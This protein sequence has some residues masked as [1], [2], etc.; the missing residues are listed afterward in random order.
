[1]KQLVLVAAAILFVMVG[2]S[3]LKIYQWRGD[4]RDGVYAEKN[5]QE[6]WSETG[7][8]LL[9]KFNGIGNGY[10]SPVVT[11]DALYVCGEID[12]VTYLFAY[13]LNGGKLWQS[14]IG[15]EWT[16]NFRGSRSAPTIVNDLIYAT[17][18]N[19]DLVCFKLIDGTKLWSRNFISDFG[20]RN[21]RFG[22]SE[23]VLVDEDKVY[24]TPGSKDTNVVALNRFTGEL[25][26]VC[27]GEGEIPAY[28]APIM[29]EL[30]KRKIMVTFTKKYLLGIDSKTGEMLWS[31]KQDTMP[32]S[33]LDV[34][35]N[36]P[37]YENGFLYYVTGDGNGAVKL[38]L[39]DDGKTITEIW[40][41][42]LFDNV[43]GGFIKKDNYLY[44]ESYGKR[45]WLSL[46]TETGELV[47]SLR[48]NKGVTIFADGKLYLYNNKGEMALVQADKGKMEI[49][50][51]F[52][53]EK[54]TKEHFFFFFIKNGVLYLRHGELLMAYD[55]RKK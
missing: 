43:M 53:V 18:G 47:D 39:S 6:K 15:S 33:L 20:G 19:G 31:H 24:C 35:C 41:N 11:E 4:N 25:I 45:I 36:T 8:E 54:G 5:L 27:R 1:M 50:S 29:V 28:T 42:V 30:S 37:L 2:V 22:F 49:I 13:N 51:S 9:W 52:K 46:N 12:S 16:V 7:P 55:I 40:R 3:P 14:K 26:W 21:N 44:G 34:H 10:G 23:S 38:K 32:E 48:F 17:S